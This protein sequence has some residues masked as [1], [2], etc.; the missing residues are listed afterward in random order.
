[1]HEIVRSSKSIERVPGQ[2]G[3]PNCYG[4][5]SQLLPT[6]LSPGFFKSTRLVMDRCN[7]GVSAMLMALA[8][9]ISD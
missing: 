7:F 3:F 5:Q 9:G 8:V 2:G 1:M 4:R 6:L